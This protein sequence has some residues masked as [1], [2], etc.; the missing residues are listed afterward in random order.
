MISN[1]SSDDGDD[2]DDDG[3]DD[4][5]D[6]DVYDE[7]GTNLDKSFQEDADGDIE[8]N[9]VS[10]STS[11]PKPKQGQRRISSAADSTLKIKVMNKDVQ[12]ACMDDL[13][14]SN[15]N[16]MIRFVIDKKNGM[17]QWSL[18]DNAY[19]LRCKTTITTSSSYRDLFDYI[20]EQLEDLK[21]TLCK[22]EES[23]FFYDSVMRSR[24]PNSNNSIYDDKSNH[25]LPITT[26]HEFC[27]ALVTGGNEFIQDKEIDGNN[28]NNN[29]ENESNT[30]V[31]VSAETE[32]T[33]T[34]Y[35]ILDMVVRAK[36]AKKTTRGKSNAI[37]QVKVVVLDMVMKKKKNEEAYYCETEDEFGCI[38]YDYDTLGTT[39]RVGNVRLDIWKALNDKG[40]GSCVG[41]KSKLYIKTNARKTC[42]MIEVPTSVSLSTQLD[43]LSKKQGKVI[44]KINDTKTLVVYMAL[45]KKIVEDDE[46]KGLPNVSFTQGSPPVSPTI[47]EATL[48]GKESRAAT[49]SSAPI[50]QWIS[51]M[52]WTDEKSQYKN[53]LTSE[54]V[55]IIKMRCATK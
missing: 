40:K 44:E 4:Y 23:S 14:S 24:L 7:Y 22:Y 25:L 36:R 53:K 35:V 13:K 39:M 46:H 17:P 51:D 12:N 43:I 33:P 28:N 9:I 55:S 54:M 26:T 10:T 29:N 34:T 18:A 27:K 37:V 41:V 42:P 6:G 48:S 8:Y 20:T 38:L 21:F 19:Y 45:G 32:F 5:C 30:T 2:S 15:Y 31:A 11:T 3:D 49:W 50:A 16:V 47:A 52:Y 1:I